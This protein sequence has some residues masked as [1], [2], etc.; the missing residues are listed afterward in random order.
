MA[1]ATLH[2]L[3]PRPHRSKSPPPPDPPAWRTVCLPSHP[4]PSPSSHS[5]TYP[6]PIHIANP[7]DVASAYIFTSEIPP[8]RNTKSP[9][10]SILFASPPY[11]STPSKPENPALVV[12]HQSRTHACIWDEPSIIPLSR[13][14]QSTPATYSAV[15][16]SNIPNPDHAGPSLS[17]ATQKQRFSNSPRC[18]LLF[19]RRAPPPSADPPSPSPHNRPDSPP[20]IY[21]HIYADIYVALTLPSPTSVHLPLTNGLAA[22]VLVPPC[23]LLIPFKSACPSHPLP[24]LVPTPPP[25]NPSI[26]PAAVGPLPTGIC[27]RHPLRHPSILQC[28]NHP[29]MLIC[30]SRAARIRRR[31]RP[32][33]AIAP[34]TA[35][36][37]TG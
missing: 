9:P 18:I 22:A 29:I 3:A 30:I 17:P 33:D 4:P 34:R 20:D 8:R 37:P 19:H 11:N 28:W 36:S 2:R 7:S 13:V 24:T 16:T 32:I 23:S 6:S 12:P 25:P 1:N 31:A 26:I 21:A 5:T 10:P 15:S 14:L 35:R 27:R